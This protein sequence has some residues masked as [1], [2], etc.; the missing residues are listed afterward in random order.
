[1]RLFFGIF[2]PRQVQEALKT[3]QDKVAGYRG[4]KVG[5]TDQLH[6]TL[7]FLGET[8]EARLPELRE[9][10][11]RVASTVPAFQVQLGGTGYFPASGAPRVWFV[12]ALGDGL[13]PLAAAL[14]QALPEA[15]GKEKFHPHLTLAR[16]KS[17]A[18]RV[19][20][21]TLDLAFQAREVCLVESTLDPRGSQYRVLE[22]FVLKGQGVAGRRPQ[23][24][25]QD[26]EAVLLNH[27]SREA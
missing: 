22:R 24:A 18:P 7:L 16:K 1:M 12:K 2:P 21:L 4:W 8:D 13:E 14:R 20:P 3:A 27:S 26:Q 23:A 10:G 9:L 11:R 19:A 17:P 6:I 5:K 25:G 15:E